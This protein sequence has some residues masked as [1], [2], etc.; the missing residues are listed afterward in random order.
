VPTTHTG[1]LISRIVA[2]QIGSF[3]R[4]GEFLREP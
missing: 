1:M 2:E 4:R 3:L